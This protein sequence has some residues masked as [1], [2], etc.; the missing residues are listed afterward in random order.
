M[1]DAIV[2]PDSK[3]VPGLDVIRG[4]AISLVLVCH[5]AGAFYGT[6]SRAGKLI[7]QIALAGNLGV[8][9]FFV[10]SG[11]LITG[12][13][14]DTSKRKDYF[15]QFYFRRVLRILP[16][17]LLVLVI[18]KVAGVTSWRF[19][20]ASLLFMSNMSGIFGAAPS[21]YGVL[22]SLSVEEQFYLVWPFVVR[23]FRMRTLFYVA[24]S[25]CILTPALRFCLSLM[26][27]D[28][29]YKTW[30]SADQLMYGGIIA[31]AVRL[32]ILPQAKMV[33]LRRW[34]L[35]IAAFSIPVAFAVW[36]A[37]HGRIGTA[38]TDGFVVMPFDALW[39]ALLL[40][41]ISGPKLAP[42]PWRSVLIF[43]GYISY[44]LYLIHQLVFMLYDRLFAGTWVG[45]FHYQL[46]PLFLRIAVCVSVSI[47][48]AYLSRR[49]FEEPFLRLKRRG[50]E[51]G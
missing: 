21:E 45:D 3:H 6:Q 10:L 25:V 13:L 29:F 39:V 35:V 11:F 41:A 7:S 36:H 24:A 47:L 37:P 14:L 42:S 28:A 46:A 19:T 26:H 2:R 8:H 32:H 4:L 43:L 22:W 44:G 18:A 5:S 17:Y 51:A 12:I 49:Y 48:L 16:V 20:L 40:F 23:A 33:R 15:R 30:A 31:I 27:M 34:L 50:A 1:P 38:L 9:L